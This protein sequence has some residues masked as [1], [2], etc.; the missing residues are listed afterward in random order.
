MHVMLALAEE[1]A[2]QLECAPR[3]HICQSC[4]HCMTINC[5]LIVGAV[6]LAAPKDSARWEPLHGDT[7]DCCTHA[8]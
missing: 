2:V 6:G 8:L 5:G 1:L 7:S 3:P 4:V